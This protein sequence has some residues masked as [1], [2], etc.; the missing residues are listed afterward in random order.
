ME[1]SLII[2]PR[3]KLVFL[4]IL[5]KMALKKHRVIVLITIK[6]KLMQNGM[7]Y[8]AFVQTPN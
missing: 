8:M 1:L 7:V 6:L 5:K 3:R 4:V 2:I